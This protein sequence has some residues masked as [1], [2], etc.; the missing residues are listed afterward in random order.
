MSITEMDPLCFSCIS[1]QTLCQFEHAKRFYCCLNSEKT[2]CPPAT[3]SCPRVY[4]EAVAPRRRF[5]C[6][7]RPNIS[8]QFDFACHTAG[9]KFLRVQVASFFIA[10]SR[11]DSDNAAALQPT[12]CSTTGH[13]H[14]QAAAGCKLFAFTCC[15][16]KLCKIYCQI[17]GDLY[18]VYNVRSR[19]LIRLETNVQWS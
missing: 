13:D 11:L 17:N 19:R 1:W 18:V 2:P 4:V 15:W 5:L 9:S 7:F 3:S 16:L 6:T 10:A 14:S 12:V 8:T